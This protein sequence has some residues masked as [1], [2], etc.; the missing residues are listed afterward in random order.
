LRHSGLTDE[1]I[2]A[3]GIY[4][5]PPD[6]VGKKLGG[7][8]HGVDSL[9]AFPYPGCEGFERYRVFYLDGK[10]DPKYRQPAGTPN[11]LYIPPG[12][13]L[14]GDGP[15]FVGEGEKKALKLTQEGFPCVGLGGV[16]GW[17]K[18]GEGYKKPKEHRPIPDLDLFNWRR[19]V[20]IV[21]DS[22]AHSNPM[23]RL[24]AFRLARELSRRGAKVSILFLPAGPKGEKVGADDFL[25][26]HGVEAFKELLK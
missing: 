22:D 18:K 3:A 4:T 16:W 9:L 25:V 20:T 14:A 19:P 13:D 2:R 21:F 11:R 1:T 8:D 12:V 23:I 5:V 15:L 10:T 7:N 24:A 6:E 26:A 17:C